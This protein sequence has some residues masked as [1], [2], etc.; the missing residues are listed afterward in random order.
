MEAARENLTQAVSEMEWS[1]AS[2]TDRAWTLLGLARAAYLSASLGVASR[3][4]FPA[5]RERRLDLLAD[6]VEAHLDVDALLSLARAG[7]AD[8]LPLLPP[9]ASR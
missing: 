2:P 5:A 6:L 9:G 3:A 4:S 1:S 8:A 7:A